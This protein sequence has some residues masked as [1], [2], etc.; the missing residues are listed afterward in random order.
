M[1][2][3]GPSRIRVEEGMRLRIYGVW[4]LPGEHRVLRL[5]T[6]DDIGS[7]GQEFLAGLG[8]IAHQVKDLD[9]A[10]VVH[11]PDNWLAGAPQD[12][13]QPG[14]ALCEIEN[15]GVKEQADLL[16]PSRHRGRS[17]YQ[18]RRCSNVTFRPMRWCCA[19]R[20]G[21]IATNDAIMRASSG[22]FLAR[23]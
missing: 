8:V 2:D 12:R 7:N 5:P 15:S 14:T 13:H 3:V 18:R 21:M 9:G 1:P 10:S 16:R 4:R 22:W 17:I 20:V 11:V 23:R 19:G 6:V